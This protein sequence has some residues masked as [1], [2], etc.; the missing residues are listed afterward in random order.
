M[1]FHETPDPIALSRPWHPYGIT[2]M[3]MPHDYAFVSPCTNIPLQPSLDDHLKWQLLA[4]FVLF[5]RVVKR[6]GVSQFQWVQ[7]SKAVMRGGVLIGRVLLDRTVQ[8]RRVADSNSPA[9]G[10]N[11]SFNFQALPL[12]SEVTPNL[13][14]NLFGI[15]GYSLKVSRGLNLSAGELVL[16][17]LTCQVRS[18]RTLPIKTHP[19]ITSS[20]ISDLVCSFYTSCFLLWD[21]LSS[22]I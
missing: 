8:V 2:S 18:R 17:A 21:T 3:P 20:L 15:S 1:G 6:P 11:L 5:Q 12:Q 19:I 10:F 22:T 13:Y 14:G 16:A 4:P 7:M 9:I